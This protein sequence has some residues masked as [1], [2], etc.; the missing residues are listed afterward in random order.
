MEHLFGNNAYPIVTNESDIV[1]AYNLPT[2]R[3][4][5]LRDESAWQREADIF[6]AG[7]VMNSN[8]ELAQMYHS[9]DGDPNNRRYAG[10]V[11]YTDV[12]NAQTI[13]EESARAEI[14]V[15]PEAAD[16]FQAR[17]NYMRPL[18]DRLHTQLYG[19]HEDESIVGHAMFTPKGG[20]GRSPM[21]HVDD[22]RLT[23]HGTFAG[24][25]LKL[26]NGVTSETMWELMDKTKSNALPPQVR[27]ANDD[28]LTRM[29]ADYADEFSSAR[30]G[31]L[32][33]MKGQ[34]EQDMSDPD[35]REEMGVHVSSPAISYQGQAA[36]IFYQKKT[37]D[38]E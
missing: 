34:K 6:K 14:N 22:V 16:L 33:L 35:V 18:Y 38:I 24:A 9:I 23:M 25:T 8:P 27:D 4:V 19:E 31:D 26:L 11:S 17:M 1:E 28:Q 5:I 21:M 29:T 7:I 15:T 10:D 2:T 32:I 30:L 37:L 12:L 20:A 36:A 3:A 13:L